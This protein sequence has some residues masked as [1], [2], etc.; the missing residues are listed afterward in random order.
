MYRE[1]YELVKQIP[2][3]KVT[4]YGEI[5][6]V[7]GLNSR[8]VGRILGENVDLEGIPCYRVVCGDGSLGGY[9]LGGELKARLLSCDGVGVVSG[10]VVKFKEKLFKF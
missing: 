2:K 9:V 8:L 3:G 1:V 7:L 10:K 6:K 4:T 5:G